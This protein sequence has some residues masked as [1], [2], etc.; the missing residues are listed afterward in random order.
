MSIAMKQDHD[1]VRLTKR[2]LREVVDAATTHR[3]RGWAEAV[4]AELDNPE[5][6]M[7]A[8]EEAQ[9]GIIGQAGLKI[10][11][12]GGSRAAATMT[13]FDPRN[14]G[15]GIGTVVMR[16]LLAYAFQ[17]VGL[18]QVAISAD[19][20][21]I[22]ALKCY[23]K[24]GFGEVRKREDGAVLMLARR[25]TWLAANPDVRAED[26][27]PECTRYYQPDDGQSGA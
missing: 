13:L 27:A 26:I 25:D 2:A 5:I 6:P 14:R 17:Q 22:A 18:S 7:F 9:K 11:P 10:W 4:A 24:A 23:R 16:H 8:I 19:A 3:M 15:V 20:N 1:R 21:N 12:K